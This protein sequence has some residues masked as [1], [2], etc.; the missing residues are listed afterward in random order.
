MQPMPLEIEM[1]ADAEDEYLS[2]N[3]F[4]QLF[5]NKMMNIDGTKGLAYK[6]FSHMTE[7]TEASNTSPDE[8][9]GS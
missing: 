7:S 9:S 1:D 5:K 6:Q 4:S 8:D 2:T 3:H